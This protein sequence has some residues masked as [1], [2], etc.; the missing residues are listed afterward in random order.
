M[1]GSPLGQFPDIRSGSVIENDNIVYTLTIPAELQYNG[2]EVECV[3]F[4][5]N[6]SPTEESPPATLLFTPT[7]R[8]PGDSVHN[9]EKN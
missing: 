7:T 9:I 2:T 5:I 4:F 3:A 8:P 6:G 1:N